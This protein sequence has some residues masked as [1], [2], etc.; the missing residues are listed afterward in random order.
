M[1]RSRLQS[2]GFV[3]S[4]VLSAGQNHMGYNVLIDVMEIMS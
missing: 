4:Q 2:A 3:L 1:V